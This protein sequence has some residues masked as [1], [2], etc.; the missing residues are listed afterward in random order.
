MSDSVTAIAP[1]SRLSAERHGVILDAVIDLVRKVGYEAMTMDAI[2]AN[3][4]T[5]KATLYRQWGGRAGLVVA[6]LERYHPHPSS[7][8][9][10]GSLRGDLLGRVAQM[11]EKSAADVE[12]FGGLVRAVSVDEEL[13]EVIRT[14]LIDPGL[15]ELDAVFE[16]AIARG[17]I[18]PD[19]P[20]LAHVGYLI[21]AFG[22][23][24]HFLRGAPA[25][26]ADLTRLIDDVVV[27]AL[28]T[29]A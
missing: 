11:D 19:N 10:T 4:H 25:T 29:S 21:A 5:S 2:A 15:S 9:D 28:T 18:A 8:P 3:A 1:R 14:R 26:A 12:L 27:P 24:H 6:A 23:A 20:A 17:E 16:R 7:P 22:L 13:R